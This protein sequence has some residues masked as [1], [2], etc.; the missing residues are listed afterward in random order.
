MS[1]PMRSQVLVSL[2]LALLCG[3]CSNSRLADGSDTQPTLVK[4]SPETFL[5][6][7]PCLPGDLG[8]LQSYSVNLF[9][10]GEAPDGGPG[11]QELIASSPPV[12]CRTAVSFQ[13]TSTRLYVA[14]IRGYDQA[15][16]DGVEP[17]W[18][19]ACGRGADGQGAPQIDVGSNDF[20]ATRASLNLTVPMVGCTYLRELTPGTTETR[21]VVSLA[22][23]LGELECGSGPGQVSDFVAVLGG[24]SQA[25]SCT[26]E[27]SFTGVPL[28]APLTIRVSA[29][30]GGAVVDAGAPTDASTPAD[31]STPVAVDAG[32]AGAAP[33]DAAPPPLVTAPIDAGLDASLVAPG[34]VP[35]WTTECSARA[36]AGVVTH[37]DCEPLL[38]VVS[39]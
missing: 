23:A 39:D 6:A 17:R 31:A 9:V 14:D 2:S 5:G 10:I 18:A 35:Q 37:A 28:D 25:A 20:G 24:Q 26:G 7:V 15:P 13:A 12:S 22:E 3:G 29:F 32:D 30:S 21:V 16:A 4:L 27:A 33:A 38:S 11:E 8:A 19:A 1:A 34:R 36:Y